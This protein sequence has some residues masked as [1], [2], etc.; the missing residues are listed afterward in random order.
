MQ[1]TQAF[2]ASIHRYVTKQNKQKESNVFV[3][4]F[5]KKKKPFAAY[6]NGQRQGRIMEKPFSMGDCIATENFLEGNRKALDVDREMKL[7]LDAARKG[8]QDQEKA[9]KMKDLGLER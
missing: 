5:E 4:S 1:E 3:S 6:V 2:L 7:A 8:T 9:Q